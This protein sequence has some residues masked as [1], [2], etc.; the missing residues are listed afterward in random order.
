MA[1]I[2]SVD[3]GA[4]GIVKAMLGDGSLVV[5]R[6]YFFAD[7]WPDNAGTAAPLLVSGLEL[8]DACLATAVAASDAERRA[9]VLIA[10]AEQ[11]RRGLE[12]KLSIRKFAAPAITLAL[13]RLEAQS[14]LSDLRY[15]KAWIRQRLRTHAE[16]PL[17][18][19]AALAAKG[20]DRGAVQEAIGTTL[21]ADDRTGIL[22]MAKAR[23][24]QRGL[25]GVDLKH[26]LVSLGWRPNEVS[27]M[28]LDTSSD[29]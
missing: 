1:R 11:Y 21:S 29:A 7:T 2:I 10:R 26:A 23:M 3:E 9:L 22:E 25:A 16:G 13:D 6:S 27:L 5:F 15:A 18:L 14:L 20:V 17:S 4:P 12:R 24:V 19:A 28:I 8:P